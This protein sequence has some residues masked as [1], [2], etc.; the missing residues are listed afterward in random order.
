M[1]WH[2][3]LTGNRRDN[4]NTIMPKMWF[5]YKH[6]RWTGVVKGSLLMAAWNDSGCVISVIS[7]GIVLQS[8]W[9]CHSWGSK[10]KLQ[11]AG[12]DTVETEWITRLLLCSRHATWYGLSVSNTDFGLF[13]DDTAVS[14]CDTDLRQITEKQFMNSPWAYVYECIC[15]AKQ[16]SFI[17]D[18]TTTSFFR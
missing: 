5:S 6:F 8:L 12:T 1:W 2:C 9:S 10:C 11:Y 3:Q 16:N 15:V 14:R 17:V 18:T 4:I 13:W 7:F